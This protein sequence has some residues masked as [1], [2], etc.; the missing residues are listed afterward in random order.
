MTVTTVLGPIAPDELGRVD[1]HEH[2]FLQSPILPGDEFQDPTR[3][4]EELGYVKGSGIDTVIDLTPIGLGRRPTAT[5]QISRAAGVHVVLATGI[6][7]KAHYPSGHWV[8][9]IGVDELAGL[10]L[11]DLQV[12]IDDRDWKGPTPAPTGVRAG[13]IKLGASYHA[14]SEPEQR[15]MTAGAQAATEA[16]V[17]IAVHTEVGTVAHEVLDLLAAAGVPPQA[18]MLAHLDRN[19]DASLHAE[20]ASRGAFL[21]YDTIG[22]TKYHPD[23]AVLD[24]IQA[25]GERGHWDRILLGTDVGRSSMLRAY[26]GGPGMDVLGR[27][28]LPRV[29]RSLG[30]DTERQLMVENPRRFLS[31]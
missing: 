22:R 30:A 24:L 12:G 7:R 31:G 25:V 2:L 11:T 5:A 3:M 10:M 14:I 1:A 26:G 19:P 16:R 13:I 20:L 4:A 15:W 29:V 8:Y 21:G 9:D 18:V 28:F 27:T 23:S 6:H 17:P